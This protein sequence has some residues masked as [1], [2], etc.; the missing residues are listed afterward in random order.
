MKLEPREPILLTKVGTP[1]CIALYDQDAATEA[2]RYYA[3]FCTRRSNYVVYAILDTATDIVI[4]TFK[5][6][7]KK[8]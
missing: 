2:Q 8:P 5:L 6:P 1:L 3:Y 4:G 7:N